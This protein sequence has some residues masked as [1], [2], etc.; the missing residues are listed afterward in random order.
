M[1]MSF[2]QMGDLTARQQREVAYH[3][4]HAASLNQKDRVLD[5]AV[6][7]ARGRRWWNA[8]WDVWTL[9]RGMELSGAR[10]LVIGCGAGQDAFYFASLGA[11]VSAFDLSAEM[12][13]IGI[14]LAEAS[15]L[16]V[17][18]SLMPSE[19]MTYPD[20][21]FDVVFAR[22]ILHHVDI[23]ATMRQVARVSKNGALFIA[24]EIYS[25]SL[26]ELVR[27][28]RLVERKL[29]PKMQRFIYKG[30]KPYIT[31]DER[32]MSEGDIAAVE[33]HLSAITYRKY[34]NFLVTR[35]FPE[36]RLWISKIDR[37]LLM[38]A[39]PLGRILAGRIVFAGR[40]GK[41]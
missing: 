39:G 41:S 30:A 13:Q 12:L 5:F 35:I 8:Y 22:D 19:R 40:I 36:K 18:F 16:P 1:H 14:E 7:T 27:R 25:H 3:R 17:T 6:V 23:P 38:L 20:N 34:F 37:L 4:D 24:D 32:K 33:A 10:V 21:S 2:D 31:R 28:S 15:G 29:Y 11:Q 9:I 26:T